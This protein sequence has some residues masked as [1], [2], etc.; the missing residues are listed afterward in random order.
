M[1]TEVVIQTGRP[2]GDDDDDF[3]DSIDVNS[4]YKEEELKKESFSSV[5]YKVSTEK[6]EK[7]DLFKTSSTEEIEIKKVC[8]KSKSEVKESREETKESSIT[9]NDHTVKMNKTVKE[10]SSKTKASEKV[11]ITKESTSPTSE[12]EINVT[13]DVHREE[14]TEKHEENTESIFL[15]ME[16][17]RGPINPSDQLLKAKAEWDAVE[18]IQP[19]K[20][21]QIVATPLISFNETLAHFQR[22][23]MQVYL[24]KIKPTVQ[25]SGFAALKHALFGPPKLNRSLHDERN[26]V[27]AIAQC[28]LDDN[29]PLH[30]RVLQTIYRQLTGS[31]IDCPRYG[32][33]WEQIGFQ[34]TDPA[35]DLRACGFL[36]L[37][38]LLH[39]VMDPNNIQV[40]R[41]IYKLSLHET[42]NFPF[43]VM[44]INITRIALQML[45]EEVLSRE[46]NSRKQVFAVLNDFNA[47]LYYQL[48]NTWK[49]EHKTISDSGL[50]LK[51]LEVN[52]RKNSKTILRNFANHIATK[53]EAEAK[54]SVMPATGNGEEG[55]GFAGVHELEEG[56]T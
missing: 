41:E 40:A 30:K 10:E 44:S 13:S 8:S 36:G 35:T 31:T 23:D 11:V 12:P 46:C 24:D 15:K 28:P 3:K 38:T 45:R 5:N 50:V 54:A 9:E 51:E 55:L 19:G 32:S 1:E 18:T 53:C 42:Q 14:V 2:S 43:A 25:R 39:F 16:G 22:K 20:H 56:E 37:M 6:Y 27:F 34:G 17:S 4:S 21:T 7:V 47:S 26:L 48:C 49:Q 29:E 52:A 33:H